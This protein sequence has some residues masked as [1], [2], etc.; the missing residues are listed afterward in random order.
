MGRTARGS[1]QILSLGVVE[2]DDHHMVGPR[3]SELLTCSVSQPRVSSD[4]PTNAQQAILR[5]VKTILWRIDTGP[6]QIYNSDA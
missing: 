2:T 6:D 3:T 5:G 4:S 1:C